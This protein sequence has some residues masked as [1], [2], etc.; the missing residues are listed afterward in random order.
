MPVHIDQIG[1]PNHVCSS[2]KMFLNFEICAL[3]SAKTL[4]YR[5]NTKISTQTGLPLSPFKAQSVDHNSYVLN[6]EYRK[7]LIMVSERHQNE[8]N[9]PYGI[10]SGW[11][12]CRDCGDKPIAFSFIDSL[13]SKQTV[14]YDHGSHLNPQMDRPS[15]VFIVRTYTKH[16]YI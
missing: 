8:P 13:S 9:V 7:A 1:L 12:F 14:H 2:Y 6:I 4:K 10:C 15:S 11:K 16:P 3:Q 5:V